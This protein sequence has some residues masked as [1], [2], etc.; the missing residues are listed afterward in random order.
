MQYKSLTNSYARITVLC[1]GLE[2]YVRGPVAM[3]REGIDN[4]VFSGIALVKQIVTNGLKSISTKVSVKQMGVLP[5]ADNLTPGL[6][7]DPSAQATTSKTP[8][9]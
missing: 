6:V 7:Q 1:A 3:P 5:E 2:N 9:P 8:M 4:L